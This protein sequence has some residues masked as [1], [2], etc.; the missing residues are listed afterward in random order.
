MEFNLDFLR[1]TGEALSSFGKKKVD[2]D[3]RT[4][5]EKYDDF[6]KTSKVM[7]AGQTADQKAVEGIDDTSST[8]TVK[9]VLGKEE[10]KNKEDTEDSLEK[11]LANIEKVIDKFSG[12]TT[13]L[14]SSKDLVGSSSDNINIRPLDMGQIQAKAIQEEYLKPSSVPNDR[15]ALLYKDLE[16]YNLI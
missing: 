13:T 4:S 6:L 12:G 11:K 3:E 7:E 8:E 9:E 1:K 5:V 16:K 14:P 10:K 2:T 15:I